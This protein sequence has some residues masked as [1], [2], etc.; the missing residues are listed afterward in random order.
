MKL[1]CDP[2]RGRSEPL[3]LLLLDSGYD[4]SQKI[5]T[6]EDKLGDESDDNAEYLGPF[7]CLPIFEV[8]MGEGRKWV[9]S[10]WGA[11]AD[12]LGNGLGIRGIRVETPFAQ[13]RLDMIREASARF[14]DRLF[15][16]TYQEDWLSPESLC[17][18]REELVFPFLAS[19]DR[20][21][22]TSFYPPLVYTAPQG[23][24][25]TTLTAAACFSA[26]AVSLIVELWPHSFG[27]GREGGLVRA[28]FT[29]CE[30]IR[31]L[32]YSDPARKK[33]CQWASSSAR[34]G[35]WTLSPYATQADIC[36]AA[37]RDTGERQGT[38]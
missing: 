12:Y 27:S 14:L 29:N 19:L 6:P 10:E 11:I 38:Q 23:M 5:L 32:V 22:G 25:G 34:P 7:G 30:R 37:A 16:L 2:V 21:I 17:K 8:E 15:H 18:T 33:I 9:I 4:F 24:R 31:D 35:D 1:T 26:Y 13:A 36:H 3:L 28:G 20:Q